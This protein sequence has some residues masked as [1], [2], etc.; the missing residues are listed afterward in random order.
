MKNYLFIA[1]HV[2]A[3]GNLLSRV[4]NST[5]K[6]TAVSTDIKYNHLDSLTLLDNTINYN[7]KLKNFAP[8]YCDVLKYNDSLYCKQVFDFCRFIFLIRPPQETMKWIYD[9][10]SYNY[11][12][13]RL[14]RIY[15][16]SK[17]AKN[18]ICLTYDDIISRKAFPLIEDFLNIKY[19]ISNYYEPFPED[20]GILASGKIQ[21]V[22]SPEIYMPQLSDKYEKYMNKIRKNSRFVV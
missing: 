16:Y 4:L 15:Q 17:Y 1:T 5:H 22:P 7:L 19:P 13:F 14:S 11:Y 21:N 18:S 9:K 8:I 6:I 2:G 10:Y 12:R 3:G 20:T